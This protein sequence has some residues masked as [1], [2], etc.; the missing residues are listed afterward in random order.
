MTSAPIRNA[1]TKLKYCKAR[2]T[3]MR[4]RLKCFPSNLLMSYGRR[5]KKTNDL[6]AFNLSQRQIFRKS[7]ITYSIT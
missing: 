5:D 2:Q 3:T 1:S 6:M 7:Q 4:K